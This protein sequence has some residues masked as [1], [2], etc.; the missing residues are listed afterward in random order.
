MN[1][2]LK[3]PNI[4]IVGL[5]GMS[6]AGKS[7]V[8]TEFMLEDYYV[9]NCDLLARL[10]SSEQDFLREVS[11]KFEE[12]LIGKDGKLDRVKTA[13]VVFADPKKNRKYLDIIFPRITFDIL[14]TVKTCGRKNILIDA[15]LLFEAKMN[16]ICGCVVSVVAS[17][18][19]CISRIVAR[20][21]ISE[22]M[23]KARLSAQHSEKFFR[24]R[25]DFIIENSNK[26]LDD[27]EKA[28]SEI[29]KKIRKG[30]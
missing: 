6:G 1:K 15:P 20:D 9:I 24:E 14:N 12:N 18:K 29:A 22:Q 30:E 4:N 11:A 23:A 13:E 7:T 19:T 3:L 16:I 8:S 17:E 27:L 10:I 26:S 28:A 5:T 21:N 25:S 2:M